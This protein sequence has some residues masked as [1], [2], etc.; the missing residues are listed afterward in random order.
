MVVFAEVLLPYGDLAAGSSAGVLAVAGPGKIL[1]AAKQSIVTECK[2][3]CGRRA[4]RLEI[5]LPSR[6]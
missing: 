1:K 4:W 3:T 2:H 5:I 6:A